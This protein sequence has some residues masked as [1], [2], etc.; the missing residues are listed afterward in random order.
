MNKTLLS[1]GPPHRRNSCRS[2]LRIGVA[3]KYRRVGRTQIHDKE[4]GVL[5]QG[6]RELQQLIPDSR[7]VVFGIRLSQAGGVGSDNKRV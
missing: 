4:I 1:D 6:G 2:G 7:E 5:V 3:K